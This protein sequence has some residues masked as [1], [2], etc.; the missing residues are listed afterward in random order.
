MDLITLHDSQSKISDID[1]LVQKGEFSSRAE[2]YRSGAL[3][4]ITRPKARELSK[5][6]L[7]DL[8]LFGKHVKSCLDAIKND[9]LDTVKT[10]LNFVINGLMFSELLSTV[11][12]KEKDRIAFETIREGLTLYETNLSRTSDSD[13]SIKEDFFTDLQRDLTLLEEYV[14]GNSIKTPFKTR[15]HARG[16]F[17]KRG[18]IHTRRPLIESKISIPSF[19]ESLITNQIEIISNASKMK[20]MQ[21]ILK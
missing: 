2:A 20:I 3:L 4:M 7:L 17:S 5:K 14:K 6:G 21:K 12:D 19:R 15:I 9:N 13:I 16:V 1:E 18:L 11:L 10:E 8:K